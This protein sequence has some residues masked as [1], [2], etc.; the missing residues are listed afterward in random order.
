[1]MRA[2]AAIVLAVLSTW[3]LSQPACAQKRIA[4]VMGNSAYQKV[5]PLPNPTNDAGAMSAMLKGAGFDVVDLKLDLKATEMRRALRDFS[6]NARNADVAIVYFAGHGVEIEGVNYLIPVDAVLERDIDAFDEAIPLDRILTVIEPAKQ[7]RLVILDACR[8]NP[9]RRTMKHTLASRAVGRGLVMVEPASPNTMIAYAA[10]AG[11]T[12]ADGDD[13]NSPFTAALVKH[14]PRPGLDLRKAFGFVRDDVLKATRNR[15]EPFVYGSLGGDDVALVP[16]VVAPPPAAPPADPYAAARR[17]YELALQINVPSAW[18]AFIGKYPSGFYTDLAKAQRDKLVAAQTAA[19]EEARLNAARKAL[20]ESRAAEAERARIAAQAKAAQD[21]RIAADKAKAAEDAKAAREREA[22]EKQKALDEAKAAEAARAKA[23]Q[24]REALARQ[25]ALEEAKAAEAARAKA[26]AQAKA[27]ETTRLAA[28]LIAPPPRIG[29]VTKSEEPPLSSNC[30]GA[31][32]Q[33]AAL[34]S[35][36]ARALSQPE[37]CGLKARDAFR[38]C[39]DCP[40]MVMVPPGELLMGSN[41]NDIDNGIAAANEGPQHKAIVRQA[42]AVGRFEVTRDQYAAFVK[43]SGYRGGERC[44]T[45]ENNIPQERGNRSFLNPGFVQDGTHPA[46]CVSWT[47]AKAYVEWLSRTTGKSYRLLSETEFE[48]VARAGTTSRYGFGNDP[49]EICNFANGA[50]QSAKSAGLP[51][52]TPYMSCKDRYPFTAP[53]GSYPANAFGLH[54]LIGNVWE[55][56][57]DCFASDYAS[58]KPDSSARIEAGCSAH[59]LRGGDWFSTEASLRPAAR[60]KAGADARHDDIGFRVART[61][62]P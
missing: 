61:L 10:K 34:A 50:D 52:S 58:A 36:T 22:F 44:F 45:F 55:W 48:Y 20:E 16:A 12:A 46:I 25:K 56:T 42:F 7:L 9:F 60:A 57:E 39:A 30:S 24:E 17:D 54:D 15:Q 18:D 23:A 49:A 43:N 28:A 51:G 14:L 32:P 8:D 38:E 26:A 6:D 62:A 21:T 29:S 35:R 11:S 59:T 47:D 5:P 19:S 13:K 33:L 27:E 37:E 2:V 1:M 3:L 53:V 41:R 40:E 4:L 31:A